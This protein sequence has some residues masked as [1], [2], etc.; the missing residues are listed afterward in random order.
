MK[1]G[2]WPPETLIATFASER[3]D[4][5]KIDV[6]GHEETVIA[7]LAGSI[8]RYRPRL[9]IFED[10]SQRAAPGSIGSR[11][12]NLGYSI[13]GVKKKPTTL[14]YSEICSAEDYRYNDISSCRLS[15]PGAFADLQ[16]GAA[17]PLPVVGDPAPDLSAW[18]VKKS[19]DH[20]AL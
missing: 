20:T 6:E 13:F 18:T 4:V 5:I 14:E 11:L 15:E 8:A 17:S 12:H 3:I 10:R 1:I 2:T 16:E 9:I 19:Q 7:A